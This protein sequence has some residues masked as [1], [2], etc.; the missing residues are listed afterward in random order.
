L[1]DY[2]DVI[3]EPMDLST[4]EEKLK[5]HEYS[6]T[7]DFS[8]DVYKIWDNAFTYNSKDSRIFQMT[9]EMS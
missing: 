6:T 4:V 7:H 1:E 9:Q 5:N 2:F 8:L 3:K